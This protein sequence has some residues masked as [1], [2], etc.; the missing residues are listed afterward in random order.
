MISRSKPH[1]HHVAVMT[2]IVAVA[3]GCAVSYDANVVDVIAGVVSMMPDAAYA[4]HVVLGLT[5][6]VSITDNNSLVLENAAESTTFV[7]GG[8]TYLAVTSYVDSGVQILDIT[9]PSRITA[10]GSIADGGNTTDTLELLGARGITTFESGARTYAAVTSYADDGVQILDITNPYRITAAGSIDDTPSLTLLSPHGIATFVSGGTTYAA[11]A[12]FDNDGVQILGVT[13]PFSITA[14]G[15]ITD[16]G[17][18]N[19]DSPRAITSFESGGHTYVAAAAYADDGVQIMRVDIMSDTMLSG[20]QRYAF[21]QVS[22][23]M[24]PAVQAGDDQT[25]GEGDVVTLSGSTKDPDGDPITYTWSQTGPITPRITFADASASSTTF[26]APPVTGDT[27]FTLVLIADDGTQFAT[28]ALNVTVKET[29]AAFITTWAVSDSDM[30]ITLPITGTYAIL[31]GDGSHSPNVNGSQFHSY[32]AAGTYAVTVLGVGLES[33]YLHGD[34]ANA[35]QLRSIEQWGDTKWT[36]MD[37]AFGRAANMVYRATDAPDLSGVTD[38]KHMF[39]NAAS[40]DG[41]ISSWDVSKVTRMYKMFSGAASFNQPIGS[42]NVSSVT[43]M[44]H[45]FDEAD[46]F[47]QNLGKWYA[48]LNST[49]INRTDVPGVVGFVSA[50]NSPLKGHNPVYGIG[51]GADS[52]RFGIVDGNMLNMTSVAAG[53]DSYAANVTVTGNDVFEN[54]NNWRVLNVNVTGLSNNAPGA[55]AGPDLEVNN[56]DAVTLN[57]TDGTV[58]V[59]DTVAVTVLD[60]PAPDIADV[61]SITPDGLYHPGQT[62]DVRINFTRPVNLD[63]LTIQDGGR[64]AAGGTFTRMDRPSGLATVQIGDSH[65]ALVSTVYDDGVQI[66]NITDPASP[67]A[68]AA[69]ADGTNYPNLAAGYS[70]TTTQ[71]GDSYYALVASSLDN[72]VQ[73]INITDPASPAPVA[74]LNYGAAY[75]ELEGAHSITTTQIGDSH[76]ALVTGESDGVQII[77]ITD[78]ASPSP[79]AALQLGQT[80][81]A[82]R[83]PTSITTTQ[84][85]D[86]H[87]ALTTS[88][89]VNAIQ[90]INITDPASPWPVATLT[91][92]QAYPELGGAYSITTTQIGDSHYALVAADSDDGVQ[93]I[94]ITDPASP[95]PAAAL[96]DGQAY[97][98]LDGAHSI[99]TT[100][101]GDSHYALVAS[102][103]DDGV[104]IIDI[105]DPARPSPAAAL[106]DGQAYPELDGA[107]TVITTQIGDS[108]Y[109]LVAGVADDGVQIIDITDPASPFNPLMP[110][111]RMD[112]DG[113][114]RATYVGQAHGNHTL[115]FEYVV[116]DGDQTGDLAYSGTDALV[117]GHSSLTDASDSSNL[118]NV[119][120]PEPGASHSLSHNKQ[121]DLRAWPND[122]PSVDAGEPVA[123]REGVQLTLNATASDPDGDQ[124]TYSWG[125]D[126]T[127]DISL[128]NADSL[129]P[130]FTAPQVSANTTVAFT[131]TADDGADTHSD[132]VTV[133]ILDVPVVGTTNGESGQNTTVILNPDGPL[134][135]RD[136]G[137]IT[138]TNATPGMI[139][140][141][142]EAPS[143]TPADYRISWAKVGDPY[144]TWTDLTGNAFPT[145]PVHAITG[146]EESAEYMVK[147]RARYG[148]TSGDWSGEIIITAAGSANNPPTA[149]AGTAQTAQEGAT[150]TL[151]GTASDPDGDQ[152]TYSWSHYSSLE[153]ILT[154]AGSLAPSFTAPQVHGNTTITFT[155]TAD[156]GRENGTDTVQVTILDMPANSPPSVDAGEPV[157]V[158]EGVQLTLNATASDPDGDQ[159]TY[160]W[161]HDSTLDISLTSADSLSPTFTA[162]QVSANTTVAFTLTAD[163]GADTHSDAVTV[164]ILDAPVVDTTNGESGQNT[165]VTL[166]PDGPL[167]P[168]DIGRITLSNAIPGTIQAS[169]E[170]PSETP[171]DYRISW[172]KVGD[173][174]LTWTDLTGNAF[175]TDPSHTITGLEEGETYNVK[176]R[177]RYDGTSGDWSGD[178]AITITGS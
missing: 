85:G 147:V 110:Y 8:R 67:V 71:I 49:S 5:P 95:S 32:G 52:A 40:F 162:P 119:T 94:N 73:I 108:H 7:S 165:T 156:D 20:L 87:Y 3:S 148:G 1:L 141:S 101:I 65:Y 88:S 64:D 79:A 115:V 12:A 9:D 99:T 98:E 6:T 144:R 39:F 157:A 74:A 155:L 28:D 149:D 30:G 15:S 176:V 114:R 107:R 86:S 62:V 48:T 169:W 123:V 135:P 91:D 80:Y 13:N 131:L 37:G 81:P 10:A 124:L 24:P 59:H 29:D 150:V 116:K 51:A 113:D 151:S 167:G 117:L 125:H 27:T 42:W 46:A 33:I 55:E 35:R 50:Q 175:P 2:A 130:T 63:V 159:L 142:W 133:T 82:L 36:T 171:A 44:E 77:N 146:L 23:S 56:R 53:Q 174:Y 72:G 168:R 47:D 128:T 57:G 178:V 138:L 84:I 111:M 60:M 54:G 132:A 109:A 96:T 166:N 68:V 163:D 136:I 126:S 172:A 14:E 76:Y 19:L 154:G 127:L 31:W 153:I 38:M 89:R 103:H 4:T 70:I 158:R 17:S 25:V 161:S 106:T 118:S 104:Q 173:P 120:L 137:R 105:T 97:P 112:L 122:P 45:M 93:I 145:D 102:I 170:A 100:R 69:I 61:T 16:G 34:A 90:I 58:Y 26:T 129:S 22:D 66:I 152:L 134:G 164:T 83:L 41:D 92:S 43:D 143:E 21:A 140:A 160:S 139:Q 177:A 78:P 18:L 75:P 121:I 11:V